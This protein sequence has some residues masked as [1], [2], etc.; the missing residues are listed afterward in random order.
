MRHF[1]FTYIWFLTIFIL[2]C[3]NWVYPQSQVQKN[4]TYLSPQPSSKYI[5]TQQNVVFRFSNADLQ[6]ELNKVRVFIKGSISGELE[7]N[8]KLLS[9]H[10]TFIFSA[11]N[12]FVPNE[13][14]NVTI[15]SSEYISTES[16]QFHFS[17][18]SLENSKREQIAQE[19]L[20]YRFPEFSQNQTLP[21]SIIEPKL[22]I[23]NDLPAGFPEI[24]VTFRN[25]PSPGYIFIAPYSNTTGSLFNI[26]MDNNGIPIYYKKSTSGTADFKVQPSGDITYYDIPANRYYKMNSFYEITDTIKV[27]N[28]YYSDMHELRLLENGHYLLMGIDPQL[29]NMDTVVPDGHPQAVV[30]GLV[31][32]ELDASKEVVFQWRSWDHFQITDASDYVNLNDSLIDY[33]HG[34]AIE[35]LSDTNLLLSCR[36]MNE[37]TNI[38]RN[39]GEII[40]RF[41]G[42]NNMFDMVNFTDTFCM[43]HSIRLMPDGA[44]LSI[45][46]N[47]NCHTPEPYS[48]AVEY[49]LDETAMSV[50]MVDQIRNEPDIFG[51]F[52]GH[53]QRLENGN[54]IIGWGYGVPSVSEFDEENK[55]LLEI[56][57]PYPN[58]RAF[59]FDWQ[60]S[61]FESNVDE[62]NFGNIQIQDSAIQI[63]EISNNCNYPIEINNFITQFDVYSPVESLPIVLAANSLETIHIKFK[64]DSLGTYY[65]ILTLCWDIETDTLVQR[66][67]RQIKLFG[68][69]G[70]QGFSDISSQ[71]SINV[72]PNPFKNAISIYSADFLI[73]QVTIYNHIGMLVEKKDNIYSKSC[74]F[75]LNKPAGI[76]FL[77]ITTKNGN[78]F[79][80]KVLKQ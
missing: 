26:I 56:S 68:S 55:R 5:T 10:K 44:N 72:F 78:T 18:G 63:I 20:N 36:N 15:I 1:R 40:W 7:G 59:K 64:T 53:A 35:I 25:N 29:V 52:M 22:D 69:V 50:K 34:N 17:I 76:Y 42:K 73:N 41:G 14:I 66:V 54:T 70:S 75:S 48:S 37:I 13:T 9:D 4:F 19:V 32:Q 67:A 30:V 47:G 74:T 62:I 6:Y 27:S 38:N 58:Y 51:E 16:F 49:Q 61:V 23:N 43:Q 3:C 8:L 79:T 28:G 33:V 57:F 12:P 46:D 21:N 60:T 45:F 11:Q 77:K 39:T 31:V 71:K 65:D 80:T 2:G 24:T